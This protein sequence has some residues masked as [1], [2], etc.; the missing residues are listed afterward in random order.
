MV[1]S[2]KVFKKAVGRNRIRRRLYEYIRSRLPRLNNTY[3]I[4]MITTSSDLLDMP[5]DQLTE[6]LDQLFHKAN[7]LKSAEN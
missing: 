3:D 5:Q 7:L 4:V 2:K 1:V 6:H